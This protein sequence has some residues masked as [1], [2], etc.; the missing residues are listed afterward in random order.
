MLKQSPRTVKSI[1]P[2]WRL[3]VYCLNHGHFKQL[4][5]LQGSL[6]KSKARNDDTEEADYKK[7]FW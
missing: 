6:K 7:S 3:A 2:A 1:D 5:Y 4:F